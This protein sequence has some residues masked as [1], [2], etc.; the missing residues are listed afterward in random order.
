MKKKIIRWGFM[1]GIL[2]LF[3]WN[4]TW[5][6]NLS[7][8]QKITGG[9]NLYR[10]TYSKKVNNYNY[11][12]KPPNYFSF[13]GNYAISN[14]KDTISLIIWPDTFFNEDFRYGLMIFDVEIDYGYM[15]YINKD[16]QFLDRHQNDFS[17]KDIVMINKML[18]KHYQE[19]TKIM[20]LAESEWLN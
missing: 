18:N 5:Y 3:L 2:I 19:I 16:I 9:Y 11:T 10:N 7:N 8:Y 20:S 13:Q 1:I 17:E 4:F 12:I 15:F 14:R 6:L